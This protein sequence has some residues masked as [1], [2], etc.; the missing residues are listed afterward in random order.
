[1][2]YLKK[3]SPANTWKAFAGAFLTLIISLEV[4]HV[5][6]EINGNVKKTRNLEKANTEYELAGSQVNVM[7]LI[8]AGNFNSNFVHLVKY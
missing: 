5:N 8:L 3:E 2:K 6:E 4:A 7:F 1:M